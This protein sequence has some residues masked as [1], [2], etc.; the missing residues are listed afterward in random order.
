ML[1]LVYNTRALFSSRPKIEIF[2]VIEWM[3]MNLVK[4]EDEFLINVKF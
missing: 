3:E 2:V 4:L 1:N